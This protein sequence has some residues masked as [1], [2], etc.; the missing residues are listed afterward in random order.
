MLSNLQA[1]RPRLIASCT[2]VL[3]LL[4]TS[5]HALIVPSRHA[6]SAQT[7]VSAP[8]N[9]GEPANADLLF[10]GSVSS[11]G[12]GA[13]GLLSSASASQAFT[14][15]DRQTGFAGFADVALGLSSG[16]SGSAES[17]F[18]RNVIL[19]GDGE[20]DFSGEL[21]ASGNASV[22]AFL[23]VSEILDGSLISR[24]L[25][26]LTTDPAQTLHASLKAGHYVFGFRLQAQNNDPGESAL[27][28]LAFDL[29]ITPG[30]AAALPEPQSLALALVALAPA[31][32]L[33]RRGRR[34]AC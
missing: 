15:H 34:S 8:D 9:L 1:F 14:R 10:Q 23:T 6:L 25:V 17:S 12:I 4:S 3:G 29:Q 33:R 21:Q 22:E 32:A 11:V 18:R 24:F 13:Q 26:D 19:S 20:F 5:A 7:S 30:D 2:L 31:L 28:H 27:G 16:V